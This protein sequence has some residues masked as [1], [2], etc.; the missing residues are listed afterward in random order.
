MGVAALL[1]LMGQHLLAIA[2]LACAVFS[3]IVLLLLAVHTDGA[4][5]RPVPF[6]TYG[7]AAGILAITFLSWGGFRLAGGSSLWGGVLPGEKPAVQNLIAGLFENNAVF[8]LLIASGVFLTVAL[9]A[10]GAVADNGE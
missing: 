9:V 4:K 10:A 6:R 2:V 8:P 3:L 7:G 5:M 1:W